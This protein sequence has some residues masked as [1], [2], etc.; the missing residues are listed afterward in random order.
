MS[1][2]RLYEEIRK[3]LGVSPGEFQKQHRMQ[4]ALALLKQGYS[5]THI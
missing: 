5:V 3:N 1:R 4:K 2:N